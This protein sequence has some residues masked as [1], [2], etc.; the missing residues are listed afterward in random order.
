MYRLKSVHSE[1]N[2]SGAGSSWYRLS[3]LALSA[4]SSRSA[5]MRRKVRKM[6]SMQAMGVSRSRNTGLR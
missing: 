5:L 6:L 3:P 2:R 1:P 4:V